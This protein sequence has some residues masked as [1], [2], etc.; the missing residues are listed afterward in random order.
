MITTASVAPYIRRAKLSNSRWFG[1]HL[2]SFLATSID[3]DGQFAL[4]EVM[5]PAGQEPPAH[6]HRID[7]EAFYIL[8]GEIEFR[9]GCETVL[10]RKGDFVLLPAGIEHSFRVLG[11]PARVLLISAPGGLDEVFTE[12]SQPARR[13]GIRTNPPPLDLGSFLTGFGRKGLSFA[14]L[15]A[16]PV[17]LA[18][19]SNPALATRPAVGLSRWYCGQLLTPLTTGS[20]TNGRFAMIEALG[21]RGEEPPLHVHE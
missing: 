4:M 7:D 2:F 16:P 13:M 1:S 14:P 17:S 5:L 18:L 21:R 9:I 10:A 15:N 19:K 11:P 20:E 6:T 8:G 3:T 12:L